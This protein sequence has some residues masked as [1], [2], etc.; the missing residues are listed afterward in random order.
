L[1]PSC[2]P[3]ACTYGTSTDVKDPARDRCETSPSMVATF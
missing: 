3:I 1:L 2:I